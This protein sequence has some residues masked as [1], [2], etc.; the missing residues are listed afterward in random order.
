MLLAFAG[1]FKAPMV[2]HGKQPHITSLIPESTSSAPVSGTAPAAIT[3]PSSPKGEKHSWLR[4]FLAVGHPSSTS[5]SRPSSASANFVNQCLVACEDSSGVAAGGLIVHPATIEQWED[6]KDLYCCDGGAS[7]LKVVYEAG[8][9]QS[10]VLTFD[11]DIAAKNTTCHEIYDL[12]SNIAKKTGSET[13][14]NILPYEIRFVP[15]DD[16]CVIEPLSGVFCSN[17][18]DT[19]VVSNGTE[20]CFAAVDPSTH[21]ILFNQEIGTNVY[22]YFVPFG[23]NDPGVLAGLIHASCSKPIVPPYAA[24]F[25]DPCGHF[26]EESVLINVDYYTGNIP[27][28]S[29][30]DGISTGYY[31]SATSAMADGEYEGSYQHEFDITFGSCGCNCENYQGTPISNPNHFDLP[32][33]SPVITSIGAPSGGQGSPGPGIV[34]PERCTSTCSK[35]IFENC[36][37]GDSAGPDLLGQ[38]CDIYADIK[39]DIDENGE[40]SG[41]DGHRR[42]RTLEYHYDRIETIEHI[43]ALLD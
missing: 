36:F 18:F 11:A 22:P 10:G 28:L 42:L 26:D 8:N 23:D 25:R 31:E 29:F 41:D 7:Y 30:V 27:Y 1:S 37:F 38:A 32:T 34:P 33:P 43:L 20:V 39:N 17:S 15:C 16:A 35:Y 12:T 19:V 6:T 24:I 5:S 13:Y 9:G 2:V 14:D 40:D 3:E 4:R 21:K